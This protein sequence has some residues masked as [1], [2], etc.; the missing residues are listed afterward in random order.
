MVLQLQGFMTML[1][2]WA[3]K[4]M[5]S[6]KPDII[7]GGADD[8]YLLRWHIIPRNGFFNIYLHRLI[9]SDDDRAL[10]D[11]PFPNVSYIIRGGYDE[12]TIENGGVNKRTRRVAGAFKARFPSAAHRLEIVPELGDTVTLFVT[13]PRVRNWGFHC[14]KGWVFWKDF[15]ATDGNI[16]S[17]GRG[18]GE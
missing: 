2:K 3:N 14:P 12:H 15:A 18:C 1:N 10:H 16:L 17:T 11:H 6:R 5:A 8:P 13:G 4:V 9:R 7:I